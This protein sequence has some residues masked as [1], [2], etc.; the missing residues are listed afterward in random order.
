M[1][2]PNRNRR[3]Y[4]F[5]ELSI[6]SEQNN[7]YKKSVQTS[8]TSSSTESAMWME[9]FTKNQAKHTNNGYPNPNCAHLLHTI[10]Q[11]TPVPF[12]AKHSPWFFGYF[13]YYFFLSGSTNFFFLNQFVVVF[14][15]HFAS[16]D[17]LFVTLYWSLYV[18]IWYRIL[19]EIVSFF[20][21]FYSSLTVC[22]VNNN[23]STNEA[24]HS[25][26]KC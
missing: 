14:R 19:T 24:V 1:C 25:I 18:Y 2:R 17:T 15:V 21:F 9:V 12:D 20:F 11:R 7:H 10:F 5:Y 8:F 4:I 13:T 16:F 26:T 23:Y 6:W 3:I 22:V